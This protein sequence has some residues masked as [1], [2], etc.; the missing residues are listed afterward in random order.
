[1]G[2]WKFKVWPYQ[3][4]EEMLL[5]EADDDEILEV[6][7]PILT[8]RGKSKVAIKKWFRDVKAIVEADYDL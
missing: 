2:R 4:V 8:L 5:D 6:I 1:M 7:T 3:V